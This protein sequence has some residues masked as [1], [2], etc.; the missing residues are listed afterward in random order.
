MINGVHH[1]A[2]GA[3]QRQWHLI[4]IVTAVNRVT[5]NKANGGGPRIEQF[6]HPSVVLSRC[7]QPDQL[8]LAPG[9]APV[10][11]G[12]DAPGIRGLPW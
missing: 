8:P 6:H 2:A 5:R 3:K 1:G 7:T 10:H 11:R 4:A 9:A 12:V